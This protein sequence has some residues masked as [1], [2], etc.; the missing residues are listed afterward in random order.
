[1][2]AATRA[3]NAVRAHILLVNAL[4]LVFSFTK[5]SPSCFVTAGPLVDLASSSKAK[6]AALIYACR[7][8]KF[9]PAARILRLD[10]MALGSRNRDK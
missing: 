7:S 1:M 4:T 2:L 3:T 5:N 6:T 10:Q 8:K 9:S